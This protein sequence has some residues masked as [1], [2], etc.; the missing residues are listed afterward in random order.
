VI[1]RSEKCAAD[2]AGDGDAEYVPRIFGKLQ[3]G[4]VQSVRGFFYKIARLRQADA[5]GEMISQT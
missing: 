1:S 4:V 5:A 3:A 2:G